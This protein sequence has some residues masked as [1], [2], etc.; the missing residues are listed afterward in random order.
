MT[1]FP[2]ARAAKEF[3]VA[4]I[5]DEASRQRVPLSEIERKTLYFSESGWSLPDILDVAD[6]FHREYEDESYERKIAGL[7]RA[8]GGELVAPMRRRGQMPLRESALQDHYLL[9]ILDP[10][11]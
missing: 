4:Q 3:I 10:S 5:V 7:I 6:A 1:R 8:A 11:R 2:D 9:V